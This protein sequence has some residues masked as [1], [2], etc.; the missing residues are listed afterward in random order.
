MKK[1]YFVL[2]LGLLAS[3]KEHHHDEHSHAKVK[4]ILDEK[5]I[6]IDFSTHSGAIIGFEHSARSEQDKKT[7]DSKLKAFEE[8]INQMFKIEQSCNAKKQNIT[9]EKDGHHAIFRAII[10]INCIKS[11]KSNDLQFNI[12]SFYPEISELEVETIK[13]GEAKTHEIN[14]NGGKFKL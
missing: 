9:I 4:L 5:A 13:N 12:K 2:L 6:S 10:Q 1:I 8:N 7:Q 3:C 14:A 11:L